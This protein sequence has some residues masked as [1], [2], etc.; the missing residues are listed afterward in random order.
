M[1]RATSCPRECTLTVL[2]LNTV[3]EVCG[4]ATSWEE[5][6][7]VESIAWATGL[8]NRQGKRLAMGKPLNVPNADQ[9]KWRPEQHCFNEYRDTIDAYCCSPIQTTSTADLKHGTECLTYIATAGMVADGRAAAWLPVAE[10]HRNAARIVLGLADGVVPP[11][12]IVGLW[13]T[14]TSPWFS[15]S[16]AL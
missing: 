1:L 12:D 6:T 8:L 2:S 7:N 10:P 3:P 5:S 4:V 16:E 11:R 15:T 13:S 9:S 14:S